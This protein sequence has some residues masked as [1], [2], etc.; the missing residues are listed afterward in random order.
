[1]AR[2]QTFCMNKNVL[3]VA[4]ALA[5][6][7]AAGAAYYFTAKA[8]SEGPTPAPGQEEETVRYGEVAGLG[9][10]I[11]LAL[12]SKIDFVVALVAEPL[13]VS[14][15]KASNSTHASLT[16]EDMLKLDQEWRAA[17][18]AKQETDLVKSA[19]NSAVSQRLI[20]FQQAHAEFP[21]VFIADAKGLNVGQ[22]NITSD[23]YQA[24]EDWWVKGYNNGIGLIY[25]GEVEYDESAQAEVI[26]VYVPVIDPST[27]LAIGVTKALVSIT[28]LKLER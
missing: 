20:A 28:A 18:A 13:I 12:D 2:A 16:L 19:L 15:V 5:V 7:G 27:K 10:E 26:G 11:N 22:T 24:D 14:E 21:E 25:K 8:P 23:Y 1:M 4:I 3:Y 17:R 6:A 9:K